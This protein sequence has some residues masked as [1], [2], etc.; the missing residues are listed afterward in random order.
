MPKLTAQS[1]YIFAQ[2]RPGG[3]GIQIIVILR[4]ADSRSGIRKKRGEN[5][6]CEI[7][8]RRKVLKQRRAKNNTQQAAEIC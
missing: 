3:G 6:R 5:E 4:F 1:C 7:L 8:A 2:L